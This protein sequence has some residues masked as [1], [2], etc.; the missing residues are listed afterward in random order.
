MLLSGSPV[1]IDAPIVTTEATAVTDRA[2]TTIGASRG[3]SLPGIH[4]PVVVSD[5]SRNVDSWL[6]QRIRHTR[7]RGKPQQPK[8]DSLVHARRRQRRAHVV[9]HEAGKVIVDDRARRRRRRFHHQRSAVA[10]PDGLHCIHCT[11]QT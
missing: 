8:I 3:P 10:M 11:N 2:T 1:C 4:T 5:F 6:T 9:H 7:A